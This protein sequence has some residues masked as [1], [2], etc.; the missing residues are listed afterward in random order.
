[1]ELLKLHINGESTIDLKL[2]NRHGTAKWS[3]CIVINY[4]YSLVTYHHGMDIGSTTKSEPKQSVNDLCEAAQWAL[5]S[6][7][8]RLDFHE[9]LTSASDISSWHEYW[10]HHWKW[11]SMEHQRSLWSCSIGM[12]QPNSQIIFLW[13]IDILW[14]HICAAWISVLP[15]NVSVNAPSAIF[16]KLFNWHGTAEWSDFIF[17]KYWYP[18]ATYLCGMD[19]GATTNSE[20]QR[21]VNDPCEPTQLAWYSRMVRFCF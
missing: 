17:M 1:M 19:I 7:M 9:L 5:Y 21:S 16:V 2:L 10:C 13:I 12:V 8:V 4:W 14:R 11:T 6:R 20:R 15:L 3:E 18:L